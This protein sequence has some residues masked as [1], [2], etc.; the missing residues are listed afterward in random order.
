MRRLDVVAF[1]SVCLL[2]VSAAAIA[3]PSALKDTSIDSAEAKNAEQKSPAVDQR[4]H[5]ERLDGALAEFNDAVE[6]EIEKLSDEIAKLFTVATKRGDIELAKQCQAAENALRSSGDLPT[7]PFMKVARDTCQRNID[8]AARKMRYTYDQV[9]KEILKTGKVEQAEAVRNEGIS[10]TE[11]PSRTW[12]Q[13]STPPT[14]SKPQA[15]GPQKA[16][17]PMAREPTVKGDKKSLQERSSPPRSN[18]GNDSVLNS[19]GMELIRL[20]A[21]K[22]RMGDPSLGDAQYVSVEISKPF[23]LGSTEVTAG[24]FKK[25]M[26]MEPWRDQRFVQPA[27]DNPA[28]YLCWEDCA[29]FCR[30]LTELE[31]TSGHLKSNESYRLPT[32]AEWEYACRAGQETI[33]SFGDDEALLSE[34]AWWKRNAFD[35][36]E[37]YAHKVATKKPN[38]WGLYDMHGNVWEFC[39]DWYVGIYAGGVD[40]RG[41]TTGSGRVVRGGEWGQDPHTCR[42]GFRHS[43]APT[44]RRISNGFRV[45]R[46]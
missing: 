27:D 36:N 34:F 5:Q 31:R 45:V 12:K 18:K 43:L 4:P 44:D 14:G 40:P 38:A 32:E 10:L 30:K 33:F 6:Q 26:G 25:V 42:S 7:G 46:Q 15:G 28:V 35:V 29:D 24:Q 39:D 21:G 13:A 19:I 2:A 8:R 37:K 9:A 11:N 3:Q 22:F 17:T 23:L 16:S 1:A 41:P 20:P